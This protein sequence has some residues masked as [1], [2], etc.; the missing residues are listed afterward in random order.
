MAS[1]YVYLLRCADNTFYTGITTDLVRR[2]DMHCQG[3][4][5]SYVAGRGY[6]KLLYAVLADGRSDASQVEHEVKSLPRTKK[7]AFFADHDRL[8]YHHLDQSS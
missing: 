1:W 7:E 2:M 5:S 3:E 8:A 4:G 6:D